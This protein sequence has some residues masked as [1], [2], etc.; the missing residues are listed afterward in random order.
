MPRGATPLDVA[1][2]PPTTDGPPR[3]GAIPLASEAALRATKRPCRLSWK[4]PS[5]THPGDAQSR[6]GA[7]LAASELTALGAA[8]RAWG[9]HLALIYFRERVDEATAVADGEALAS[10]RR[11][12]NG[13]LIV[14][15]PSRARIER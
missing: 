8:C 11:D 7:N 2:S 1:W 13:G 10:I 6:T 14:G 3:R 5:C 9:C 12:P 4:S 15:R